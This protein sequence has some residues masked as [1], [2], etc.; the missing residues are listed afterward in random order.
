MGLKWSNMPQGAVL[1]CLVSSNSLFQLLLASS[2][3]VVLLQPKTTFSIFIM[4]LVQQKAAHSKVRQMMMIL[5]S[6]NSWYGKQHS[7][8]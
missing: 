1:V 6:P 5:K 3:E 4:A 7:V 8:Q 2:D